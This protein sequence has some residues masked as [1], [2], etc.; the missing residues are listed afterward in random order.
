LWDVDNTKFYFLTGRK[1]YEHIIGKLPHAEVV[2]KGYKLGES[3]RYL[4]N[5]VKKIRDKESISA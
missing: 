4:K 2:C 5:E 1:Y 3:L